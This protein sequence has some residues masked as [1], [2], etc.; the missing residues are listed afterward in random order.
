MGIGTV[1]EISFR[2][3]LYQLDGWLTRGASRAPISLSSHWS[4]FTQL[5]TGVE[6]HLQWELVMQK[7]RGGIFCYQ[8][9]ISMEIKVV[10]VTAVVHGPLQ[11]TI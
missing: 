11:E 10:F 7:R 4:V 9:L 8:L 1:R 2:N 6:L 3:R 5:S